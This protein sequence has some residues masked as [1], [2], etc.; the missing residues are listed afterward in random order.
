MEVTDFLDPPLRRRNVEV[1]VPSLPN[2]LWA[3]L[4]S[5][6]RVLP[7]TLGKYAPREAELQRRCAV[8]S[9]G[10]LR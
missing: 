5:F 10:W 8:A 4:D 9:S 7:V 2:A 1:I 3:A 6:T